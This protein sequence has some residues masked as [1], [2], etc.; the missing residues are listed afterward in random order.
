MLQEGGRDPMPDKPQ[1]KYLAMLLCD[2]LVMDAE[3]RNKSLIGIFNRVNASRFPVRHDRM[4]VFIA[5]TNGHG[6]REG[7]EK[8]SIFDRLRLHE[9]RSH[10][11]QARRRRSCRA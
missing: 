7:Y 3:T 11:R 8:Q 1:P 6:D 5:L 4:H 2:Y 9:R 10:D